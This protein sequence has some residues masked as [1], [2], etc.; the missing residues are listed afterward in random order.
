[1][2]SSNASKTNDSE[3]LQASFARAER[4]QLGM[5]SSGVIHR[6]QIHCKTKLNV[7]KASLRQ[8][9][10]HAEKVCCTSHSYFLH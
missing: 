8:V 9:F 4:V 10:L 6:S 2:I 1:M 3:V 5:A 7:G